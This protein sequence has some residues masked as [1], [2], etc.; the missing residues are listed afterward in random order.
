MD[1]YRVKNWSNFQHYKDR[2]PA[3]IKLHRDILDDYTFQ[4]MP[5]ASRALAPCIWLLASE[6][7]GGE[8]PADH[9]MLAFRFRRT[10]K[11]VTEALKPLIDRGFLLL[12]QDASEPLAERKPDAIPEKEGEIEKEE[13]TPANKSRGPIT[14][15]TFI[16][17]CKAS[18]ELPIPEDDP[19]FTYCDE[20]KLPQEFVELAWFEFKDRMEGKRK[21]DWR[22]HFRNCIRANWF[23]LWW[24]DGDSYSLT[25][26]GKQAKLRAQ[27]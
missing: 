13:E 4:T 16:A 2:K 12:V 26:V 17:D 25:T 24:L 15:N 23:K 9:Q 19:V 3:W 11:E 7:D 18:G 6:Y 1:K 20:V 8:I 22:A 27:A 10:E 14:L 5:D 21:K